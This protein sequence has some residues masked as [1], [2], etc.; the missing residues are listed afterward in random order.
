MDF[1]THKKELLKRLTRII[2]F[3]RIVTVWIG[4]D[5]MPGIL[6]II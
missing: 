3:A 6:K 2:F 1:R 5:C 4:K